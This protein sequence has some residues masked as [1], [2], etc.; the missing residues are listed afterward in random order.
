MVKKYWVFSEDLYTK[1]DK[2]T[3]EALEHRFGT[4]V[5]KLSDTLE[6][7]D[8]RIDELK[9]FPDDIPIM[10][11]TKDVRGLVYKLIVIEELSKIREELIGE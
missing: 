11:Y 3:Q 1:W 6:L 4:Q 2:K 9:K 10:V 7:I 5:L 8:K